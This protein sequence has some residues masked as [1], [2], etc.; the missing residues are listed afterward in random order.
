[1]ETYNVVLSFES[2]DENLWC[3]HS[4]EM[5]LAVP[6]HGTICFSI[7][8]KM[9]LWIFLKFWCLAHLG[10]KGLSMSNSCSV[11]YPGSKIS[12]PEMINV[13]QQRIQTT[14]FT[15]EVSNIAILDISIKD[16]IKKKVTIKTCNS[17]IC[18]LLIGLAPSR[19]FQP[20]LLH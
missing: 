2:V 15:A 5:S 16:K 8:H 7:F 12:C 17:I 20:R 11:T 19:G 18:N 3:D 4:N 10:V 6:F 13:A 1:M 14:K 9:K